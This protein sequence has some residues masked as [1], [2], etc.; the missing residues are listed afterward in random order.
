[1]PSLLL[2]LIPAGLIGF[3]ALAGYGCGRLGRVG[4]RN[5]DTTVWLGSGTA[6]LGA[7]AVA[8]YTWGLLHIVGAVAGAED[9]GTNSAPMAPCRSSPL[10]GHVVDYTV[11]Y[12]PLRFVC[13]TTDSGGFDAGSVPEWV[14]PTALAFTLG[15]LLAGSVLALGSGRE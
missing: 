1:M 5:A 12:V 10:A 15:A 8:V 3:F 4:L 2:L 11:E 9:G 13:L 6:L 14:N 7:V